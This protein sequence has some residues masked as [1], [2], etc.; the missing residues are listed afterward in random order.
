MDVELVPEIFKFRML[1][2]YLK[3]SQLSVYSRIG[4]ICCYEHSL[5]RVYYMFPWYSQGVSRHQQSL[6]I[7][8]FKAKSFILIL[9]KETSGR[10]RSLLLHIRHRD[11][12]PR[13]EEEE[14]YHS[15]NTGSLSYHCSTVSRHPERG[16]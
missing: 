14:N 8:A 11:S 6:I 12:S 1:N 5:A 15:G 3:S 13:E 9:N 7:L 2:S 4:S 10:H 16:Y